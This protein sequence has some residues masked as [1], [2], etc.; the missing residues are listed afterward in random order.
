MKGEKR[1]NCRLSIVMVLIASFFY[2]S[3]SFEYPHWSRFKK[4]VVIY[5]FSQC[6][7]IASVQ[8]TVLCNWFW[9]IDLFLLLFFIML[10]QMLSLAF[11]LLFLAGRETEFQNNVKCRN[12]FHPIQSSTN[13]AAALVLV[14]YTYFTSVSVTT[15]IQVS[16]FENNCLRECFI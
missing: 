8:F 15:Y 3:W 12:I 13:D 1:V 4:S 5:S 10:S 9:N 7:S 16:H 14:R 6:K 2:A 11:I